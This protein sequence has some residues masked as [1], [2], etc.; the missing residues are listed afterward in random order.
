VLRP[1]GG[2]PDT[3]PSRKEWARHFAAFIASMSCMEALAETPHPGLLLEDRDL[4][5]F[6]TQLSDLECAHARDRATPSAAGLAHSRECCSRLLG[7]LRRRYKRQQSGA[8]GAQQC[9]GSHQISLDLSPAALDR[10][11]L[12]LL[13]RTE[14]LSK[15]LSRLRVSQL[16]QK[17]GELLGQMLQEQV[18][19]THPSPKAASPARP[20]L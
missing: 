18:L 10:T 15:S 4:S 16:M 9:A 2:G 14:R 3:L 8:G 5:V 13:R 6:A 17:D 20:P 12:D 1:S 19:R 11:T 7:Q